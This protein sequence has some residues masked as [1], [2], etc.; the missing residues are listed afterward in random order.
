MTRA[1]K[2]VVVTFHGGGPYYFD[3][4]QRAGRLPH[5]TRLAAAGSSGVITSTLPVAA[6]AWVT[7]LTGLDVDQH[8]VLDT[9]VVDARDLPGRPPEP[10]SSISY[11]RETIFS[12]ASNAGLR[13]AGVEVP[14]VTPV[15]PV[16]G[17]LIPGTP[18]T[19]EVRPP[20][21]PPD[22]AGRLQPLNV[23]AL[24]SVDPRDVTA[25]RR[26][27]DFNISRVVAVT[28]ELYRS[29][30][31][32]L[33]VTVV[34][35]PDVANHLFHANPALGGA[36]RPAVEE[37]FEK[38][39]AVLDDVERE[40]SADTVL[41]V[42][43]DHG[44]GPM[45][46]W[47]FRVSSWLEQQGLLARR[48]G[49]FRSLRALELLHD[50]LRVAQRTRL[51][52]RLKAILPASWVHTGRALGHHWPFLDL[53]RTRVYPVDHFYPLAAFEVNLRGR[54]PAGVV[55]PGDEFERT[56]DRLIEALHG[57]G[58]PGGRPL[59]RRVYRR[60][61]EFTGPRAHVLAD[62]I[63]ELDL[64]VE[65]DLRF[66]TRLFE[67][68]RGH[69]GY[70]YRGYHRQEGSLLMTGPGIARGRTLTGIHVRDV[71][72]TILR[73]LGLPIPPDRRGRPIPA[74]EGSS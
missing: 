41:L 15:W 59:C 1:R 58:L 29:G 27:L 45:P 43:S 46:P 68:N 42:V 47:V 49:P 18:V 20:T 5:W 10:A 8:G 38:V 7:L 55:Q 16:N 2:V 28:K 57:L 25:C 11:Q 24:E 30:T 4:L 60:E 39:D 63:A 71:M 56:R 70:P 35:A 23:C 22:L 44:S 50:A 3:P 31:Y 61:E 37:Y 73:L 14:M 62:V 67:T 9:H 21:F 33:L 12:I 65:A 64:D 54:Q 26:Y 69:A 6:G 51:T 36:W 48:D 32:D 34:K 74:L 19:D 53:M 40:L 72:P 66:G 52:H 17:V 13:V